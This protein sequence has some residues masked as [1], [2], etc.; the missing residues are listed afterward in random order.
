MNEEM[1]FY[2]SEIIKMMNKINNEAILK[3][4]YGI[5]ESIIKEQK[6]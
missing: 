4:I 6:L 3:Y 1:E 2:K 5:I